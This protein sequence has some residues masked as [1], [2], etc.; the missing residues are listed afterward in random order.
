MSD[1]AAYLTVREAFE[2]TRVFLEAYWVRGARGS[3]DLATQISDL[4]AD[5]AQWSD[6]MEA[7]SRVKPQQE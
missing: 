6:W 7:V 3:D 1:E 4:D 2:A 5:P